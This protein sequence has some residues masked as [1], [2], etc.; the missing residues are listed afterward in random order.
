MKAANTE[1]RGSIAD[2]E[3]RARSPVGLTLAEALRYATRWRGKTVV[4]KLGGSVLEQASEATLEDV[5]LL[6][7][8]GLKPVLVHGGGI[9]IS[10]MLDRLGHT[11]RFIDGLRVTDADTMEVVEMVLTGRV[12]KRLVAGIGRQPR[13]RRRG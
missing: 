1:A 6:Q 9:E 10:R 3:E 5:V 7:R 13:P 4:I 11:P 12:N 8:A 2:F